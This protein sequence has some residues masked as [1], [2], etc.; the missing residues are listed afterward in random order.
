VDSTVFADDTGAVAYYLSGTSGWATFAAKANI[1]IQPITTNS[2]PQLT[3]VGVQGNGFG[4][5]FTGTN[6]QI[7]VVE[8][9]TD[10]A[11]SGWQPVLTNTLTGTSFNFTDPQWTNYPARF[12]RVLLLP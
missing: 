1:Q 12:Y 9:S 4:F 5:T 10:P 7:I 8:V 3:G 6:N 11:S 2:P